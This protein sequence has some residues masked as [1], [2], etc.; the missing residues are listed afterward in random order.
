MSAIC[1]EPSHVVAISGVE[2][3]TLFDTD[4]GVGYK[5]FQS[6]SHVIGTR[7]RDLERVLATGQRWP[8]FEKRKTG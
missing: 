5:V 1:R 4:Y 2:L 7:L 8:L 6:L 3:M